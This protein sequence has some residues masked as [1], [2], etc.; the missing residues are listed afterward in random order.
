MIRV[1]SWNNG[2]SA[3]ALAARLGHPR[4]IKND[5]GSRLPHGATALVNLGCTSINRNFH[6]RIIN[7]TEGVRRASS[8]VQFF[9]R[10]S[11]NGIT[12]PRYTHD[13]QEAL[14]IAARH[15]SP[16]VCRTIDNG[17]S[18]AG[19]IVVTPEQMLADGDLP[20]AH[21]YTQAIQKRREYRVHIGKNGVDCKIIDVARKVRRSGVED[22]RD[23]R[24]FVWNH[25]NDFI[26]QRSGVT[27]ETV[28]EGVLT[29]AIRCIHN[30]YLHFGAVDVIVEA[31]G[32]LADA[33]CYAL[34][35]NTSP[36]MEGTTL[37]RYALFIEHIVNG[38]QFTDWR[39]LPAFGEEYN[40]GLIEEV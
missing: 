4:L 23:D 20:D 28:P 16:I 5:G 29:A 2:A 19:I 3:R 18:G 34:E 15:N 33:K 10:F 26:F 13:K 22:S 35:V 32:T 9:Q 36:G 27:V 37:E 31:G 12:V 6:C 1:I 14:F 40:S 39:Y 25:G 17:H 24:P 30:S 8:K 21:L 38:T 11:Q 7:Y